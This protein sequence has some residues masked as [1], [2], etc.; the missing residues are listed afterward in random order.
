LVEVVV[1]IALLAGL[2]LVGFIRSGTDTGRA[3]SEGLSNLLVAE[4]QAARAEA[5]A[6]GEPVAVCFPS[7]GVPHSRS[8]YRLKGR[9]KARI[10]DIKNTSGDFRES[11][12]AV[13]HWGD[14]VNIPADSGSELDLQYWL[15]EDFSGY[16]FVFTPE[17][18]LV[19]NRLPLQNGNY[20]ILVCSALNYAGDA[21]AGGRASSLDPDYFR[22]SRA[23]APFTVTL[24]PDGRVT[25]LSGAPGLNIATQS[26]AMSA[27]PASP[28]VRETPSFSTPVLKKIEVAPLSNDNT[29][30]VTRTGTLTVRVTAEDHS[31][32]NLYLEWAEEKV[33]GAALEAGAFSPAGRNLLIWDPGEK[34]W[35]GEITWAPPRDAEIG[36]IFK[37]SC[38][39]SNSQ[40][41]EVAGTLAQ[42]NNV[43]VIDDAQFFV[44]D[45]A[46]IYE[47][48][49]NGT[50]LKRLVDGPVHNVRS[51]P[52][53]SKIVYEIE[54]GPRLAPYTYTA[55]ADGTGRS[56]LPGDIEGVWN[57]P[58]WNTFGTRLYYDTL[59]NGIISIRPDGS[60]QE[61]VLP[62]PPNYYNVGE[63]LAISADSRYIA[64]A[65]NENVYLGELDESVSPPVIRDW[66]NVTELYP[67]SWEPDPDPN[68]LEFHPQPADPDRPLLVVRERSSDSLQVLSVEDTGGSGPG[69]FSATYQPL[70]YSGGSPVT[71]QN[72]T[73][74][75]DGTEVLIIDSGDVRRYTWD[76]SGTVPVLSGAETITSGAFNYASW[77]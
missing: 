22:A 42:L 7:D 4:F 1:V 21:P 55:N 28:P 16:A 56:R 2:G 40:G 25:A 46:G 24:S 54:E 73:F 61:A 63:S 64:F 18:E 10:V 5:L 53:G 9:S 27:P 35:G 39:L 23:A 57:S 45:N 36:D 13:A 58:S 71:A 12:I 67:P 20:R 19:T 43:L 48:H 37:I 60:R 62:L 50:Q 26:F 59:H 3:S 75:P 69:R 14:G 11:L 15:P 70:I 41:S 51:S 8:F 49:E 32:D 52:D 77:R 66:S 31:G 76:N 38:T 68:F 65:D 33:S 72:L 74:K 6:G 30:T 29:A 47:L 44:S 17:G 34:E